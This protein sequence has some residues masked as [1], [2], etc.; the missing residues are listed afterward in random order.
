MTK[1]SK[2]G[3]GWSLGRWSRL[4]REAARA[5]EIPGVPA[6]EGVKAAVPVPL[7]VAAGQTPPPTARADTL[8]P[9]ESLTVDSD[10]SAFLRPKV[11]E[12]LKRQAL[13]QLFRDPHFN[14]MDGL[15][16]YV[17]DY[18]QPDPI[19][20]DVVRQMVQGRYIFDPPPTRINAQGHVEDVPPEEIAAVKANAAD[21][22]AD[23]P[24]PMDGPVAALPP[25]LPA[26]RNAVMATQV[27]RESDAQ[28]QSSRLPDGPE[29]SAR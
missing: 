29:P 2:V 14:V 6:A 11:D 19:E 13:R 20:P 9:V 27:P 18:S 28:V 17:G 8:P 12:A 23:P 21:A 7:P 22:S 10:F 26:D 1:D 5:Q 25:S 4:K 3:E 15:D 16:V 24:V